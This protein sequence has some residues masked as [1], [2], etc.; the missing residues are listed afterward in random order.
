MDVPYS[1]QNRGERLITIARVVLAAFSFLAIWLDPS[2]PAKYA[3]I[4]YTLLA[5]YLAYA[6]LVA[7]LVWSANIPLK[8][9]P[10][11][12][13]AFDLVAFAFFIYFTEGPTS[14]F[15]VYMVFALL[16]ATIRWR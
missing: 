12:T 16:C 10:L 1:P 3:Q 8:R 6:L 14:P 4:A 13:H 9:L 5:N 2:E 11:I 7:V 15:F